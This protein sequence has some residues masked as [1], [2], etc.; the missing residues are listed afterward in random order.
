MADKREEATADASEAPLE[1]VKPRRTRRATRKLKLEPDETEL[2]GRVGEE[3]PG[4]KEEAGGESGSDLRGEM[5]RRPRR[6][7][8]GARGAAANDTVQAV[9]KEEPQNIEDL[10]RLCRPW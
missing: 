10:G 2:E 7:R 8:K 5:G 3:P 6:A 4:V 9:V 1:A